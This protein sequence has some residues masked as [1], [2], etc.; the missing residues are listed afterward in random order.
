MSLLLRHQSGLPLLMEDL[1]VGSLAPMLLS[2]DAELRARAS[3]VIALMTRLGPGRLDGG[4]PLLEAVLSVIR[5]A[6]G[7]IGSGPQLVDR[8]VLRAL[9]AMGRPVHHPPRRASHAA[10]KLAGTSIN[11]HSR[12]RSP[13]CVASSLLPRTSARRMASTSIHPKTPRWHFQLIRSQVRPSPTLS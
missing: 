12:R 3:Q 4:A 11:A 5:L 10:P 13:R 7:G 6:V 9:L 8:D 1:A 2:W